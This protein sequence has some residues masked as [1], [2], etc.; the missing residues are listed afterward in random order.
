MQDFTRKLWEKQNQ[1]PGDRFRLFRA[2]GD[3]ISPK[4]VLYA[5]SYVDIAPSFI[6]PS[7]TYVDMDRRAK[8]FFDDEAGVRELIETESVVGSNASFSFVHTDYAKLSMPD[9][10]FD[11]LISLYAGFISEYCTDFLKVGGHLLVNPSHGDAAL[12]S[13]DKRYRLAGA[14]L[15]K[16]GDYRV[17]QND[18]DDYLQPKK[19]VEVTREMLFA[20]NRAVAYTRQAFA[21]LFERV[22]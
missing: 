11:L 10:S 1:H 13:I 2:V 18:L 20:T 8:H 16:A 14:V 15:S 7:V 21:Y 9:Q 4:S 5:G 17:I 22:M 6:F 19:A 3:V 12:A